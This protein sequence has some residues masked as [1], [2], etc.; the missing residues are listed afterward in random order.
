MI[1]NFTT[2]TKV[3]NF[4]KYLYDE[5]RKKWV[6]KTPEE[7]VRQNCWKFLH[8]EKRYPKSLMVIE[9]KI[10]VNGTNKRFDILIY[11]NKGKPEII[12][13][14]KAPNVKINDNV[15]AQTL[16]YQQRLNA[17]YLMISN[18]TETYFIK[19]DKEQKKAKYLKE[20]P[21]CDFFH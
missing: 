2:Q 13:E 14:C 15:L 21:N 20:I 17:S 10:T 7:I 6:I 1:P 3:I 19:V 16:S 11:N 9:K 12:V 4:K 5:L 18:G 8:Y